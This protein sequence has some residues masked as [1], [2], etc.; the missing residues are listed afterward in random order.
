MAQ[1]WL[2]G[3]ALPVEP[4]TRVQFAVWQPQHPC[5]QPPPPTPCS[6]PR[7]LI[8][9]DSCRVPLGWGSLGESETQQRQDQSPSWRPALGRE[10]QDTLQVTW[11][12]VIRPPT[13]AWGNKP[14]RGARDAWGIWSHHTQ[15]AHL[16]G[17]SVLFPYLGCT[18][19]PIEIRGPGFEVQV[20]LC[21]F[22][23]CHCTSP[24]LSSLIHKM[25]VEPALTLRT[26][27]LMLLKHIAHL[28]T[29]LAAS[30]SSLGQFPF[31]CCSVAKSCPALAGA[32]LCSCSGQDQIAGWGSIVL[33]P[34]GLS[35]C[36]TTWVPG[37]CSLGQVTLHP[38][39][40]SFLTHKM[41]IIS[42]PSQSCWN[43]KIEMIHA[44]HAV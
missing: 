4:K 32:G 13:Q 22:Q 19:R 36:D 1:T 44:G 14:Q 33:L 31:G 7:L 42:L 3:L 23:L 11:T 18:W 20:E 16:P 6:L 30:E 41:G 25:Q 38:L 28:Y 2:P 26:G 8:T 43:I 5:S 37:H 24:I 27:P 17:A 40:L 35:L 39:G 15:R 29:V 12:L 34:P 9:A 21:C 10:T